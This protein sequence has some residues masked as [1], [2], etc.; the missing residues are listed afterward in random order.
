M[1]P[2]AVVHSTRPVGAIS[3]RK[4]PRRGGTCDRKSASHHTSSGGRTRTLNNRARTCR[5]ADYTTPDRGEQVTP[6]PNPAAHVPPCGRLGR[7][8]GSRSPCRPR[9]PPS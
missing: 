5:V 4:Y 3:S 9:P 7:G 8:G 2:E 1:G 6:C